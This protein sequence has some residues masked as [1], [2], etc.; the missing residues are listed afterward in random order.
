M[1]VGILALQGAVEPHK[2]HLEAL[3]CEV[4]E[5]RRPDEFEGIDALILPGG[6]STT[7]LKLI[8]HFNLW[9]TLKKKSKEIPFWG[10]CAGSILMAKVL[11]PSQKSLAVM[12]VEVKRNA[13]G[14]Q[15]DSHQAQIVGYNVSFIRAPIVEKYSKDCKVLATHRGQAV[16]ISE[17]SHMISTFH[18]E[19]NPR[20]PSPMH[21]AFVDRVSTFIGRA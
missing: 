17:G 16:W 14:R 20:V 11:S 21:R 12:N 5:V 8:D 15:L 2:K 6:E 3:G 1:K 7:M 19:L 9:D 18:A 10:I 4:V 13:Y